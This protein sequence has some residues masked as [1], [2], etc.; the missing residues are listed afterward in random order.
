MA[1]F[2]YCL[3]VSNVVKRYHDHDNCYKGKAI[4]EN[5]LHF[6]RFSTSSSW[7]DTDVQADMMLEK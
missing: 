1:K 3:R 5:N 4:D 6:Q 2:C 7:C